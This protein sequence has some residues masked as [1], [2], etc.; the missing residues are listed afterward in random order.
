[1]LG[2]HTQGNGKLIKLLLFQFTLVLKT[3]VN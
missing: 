1:M 2:Q 3:K